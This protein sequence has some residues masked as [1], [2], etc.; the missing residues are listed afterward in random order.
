VGDWAGDGIMY[1]LCYY[2]ALVLV[3]STPR[4]MTHPLIELLRLMRNATWFL[5]MRRASGSLK[6][7]A[8]RSVS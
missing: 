5:Y 7:S 2:T 8:W 4:N 1:S 3:P 6:N